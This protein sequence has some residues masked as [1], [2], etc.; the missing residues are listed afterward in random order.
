MFDQIDIQFWRAVW[1]TVALLYWLAWEWEFHTES[2][3][4]RTRTKIFLVGLFWPLIVGVVL[5]YWI[6]KTLIEMIINQRCD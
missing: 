6:S 3:P 2:N 5:T 1:I 4:G